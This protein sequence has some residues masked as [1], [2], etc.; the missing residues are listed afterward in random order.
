VFKN[1]TTRFQLLATDPQDSSLTYTYESPGDGALA[2][3]APVLFYIPYANYVGPDSF[4]YYATNIHGLSSSPSTVNITVS[5]AGPPCFKE[6]TKILTDK[7]YREIRDLRKGDLV[8]TLKHGYVPINMIGYSRVY[9]S[10]KQE[11]IKGRLYKYPENTFPGQTEELVLTGCHS[12]LVDNFR[13]D[14]QKQKTIL[15]NGKIYVTDGKYRL[16]ACLDD[17]AIPYDQEGTYTVYHLALDNDDYYMNYG[18]FANGVLVETTSKRYLKDLSKMT[19]I[20]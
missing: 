19:L 17:F 20:E 5:S 13:D 12:R 15:V 1:T 6:D 10:G 2:G 18:I 8:K 14:V 9:N 3:T 11:R 7:S 4:T 16:P